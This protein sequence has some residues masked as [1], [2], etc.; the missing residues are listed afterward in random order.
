MGAW[1]TKPWDNDDAA[2]WFQILMDKT[3]LP[4]YVEEALQFNIEDGLGDAGAVRAAAAVLVLLGHTFVWPIDDLDRH[5]ELA[6]SR[7]EAILQKGY[8]G[9]AEES[10]RAEIDVLRSRIG[11]GAKGDAADA[12]RWWC[13]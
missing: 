6:A 4:K 3:E 9:S 7:L 5:L 2:D 8:G 11:G 13:F 12:V 1:G 10:I